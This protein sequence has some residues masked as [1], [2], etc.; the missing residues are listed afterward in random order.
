VCQWRL[1]QQTM[2]QMDAVDTAADDQHFE[3][4]M[5]FSNIGLL[6]VPNTCDRPTCLGFRLSAA[7]RL[8]CILGT[9]L[10]PIDRTRRM[11]EFAQRLI[12]S[13]SF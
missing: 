1:L 13:T 7:L 12:P 11:S 9:I 5:I 3:H 6:Q 2:R 8:L 4:Y 10:G